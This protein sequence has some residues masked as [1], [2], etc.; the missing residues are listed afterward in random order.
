MKVSII[1]HRNRINFGDF[2]Y[3]VIRI[4]REFST[5]IFS[6][7]WQVNRFS[8]LSCAADKRKKDNFQK[9][10]SIIS[11]DKAYQDYRSSPF[12]KSG[13]KSATLETVTYVLQQNGVEVT[14]KPT[15]SVS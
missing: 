8:H 9:M 1:L 15:D 10:A 11:A 13:K 12:H 7:A 2:A 14:S 5:E 4:S 3:Y 6:R